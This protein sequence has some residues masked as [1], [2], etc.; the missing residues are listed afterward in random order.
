MTDTPYWTL[1][2]SLFEGQFTYF[3]GSPIYVRGKVH[4]SEER[5][6]LQKAETDKGQYKPCEGREPIST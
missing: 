3:G 1:D 4:Q 6:S 2:T 5:S